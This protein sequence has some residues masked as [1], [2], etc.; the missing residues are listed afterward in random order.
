MIAALY[1]FL[2]DLGHH[3]INIHVLNHTQAQVRNS[4]GALPTAN[5]ISLFIHF[6]TAFLIN[7]I[8]EVLCQG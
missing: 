1:L 2:P 3:Q 7:G 4:L 8:K 5:C 6:I